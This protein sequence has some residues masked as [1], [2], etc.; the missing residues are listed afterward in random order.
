MRD[1]RIL[2]DALGILPL[3]RRDCRPTAP[4]VDPGRPVHAAVSSEPRHAYGKFRLNRLLRPHA[5]AYCFTSFFLPPPYDISYFYIICP[6]SLGPW[7]DSKTHPFQ[8]SDSGQIGPK[9]V[10]GGGRTA[11]PRP[12]SRIL[13]SRFSSLLTFVSRVVIESGAEKE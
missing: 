1:Q 8:S 6:P 10:Q 13:R 2:G 3:A 4:R 11:P 9:P 7:S 12:C 5:A